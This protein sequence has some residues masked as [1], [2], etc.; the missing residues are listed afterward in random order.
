MPYICVGEAAKRLGAN[1]IHISQLFYSQQLRSDLCPVIAG[2]RLIPLDYLDLIRAA[3]KRA[4]K[5]VGREV[6]DVH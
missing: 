2:R 3:L 6:A 5:P 4:G 1:P